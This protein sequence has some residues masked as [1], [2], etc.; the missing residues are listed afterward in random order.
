[1]LKTYELRRQRPPLCLLITK[2]TL[3]CWMSTLSVQEELMDAAR[4]LRHPKS[5]ITPLNEC[6][7]NRG[8]LTE[9]ESGRGKFCMLFFLT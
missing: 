5:S 3:F 2:R 6:Q 7:N 4:D 9:R 1:M 8:L